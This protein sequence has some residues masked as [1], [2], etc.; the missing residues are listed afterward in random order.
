[1]EYKEF[2]E[3]FKKHLAVGDYCKALEMMEDM[4][5]KYME[6]KVQCQVLEGDLAEEKKASAKLKDEIMYL[7]Q[8]W[9]PKKQGRR[10]MPWEEK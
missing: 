3:K 10:G 2:I 6:A 4:H 5:Q 8:N 7:R 9:E 1:M